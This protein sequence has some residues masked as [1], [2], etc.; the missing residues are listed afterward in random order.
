M[1]PQDRQDFP[2]L[3]RGD[4]GQYSEMYMKEI[5]KKYKLAKKEKKAKA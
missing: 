1:S 2:L 5:S 3:W 4:W